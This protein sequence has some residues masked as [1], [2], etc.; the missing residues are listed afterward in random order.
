MDLSDYLKRGL[1]K[2]Q[3]PNF[4][5][6]SR[7]ILRAEKDLQSFDRL[8]NS[9][10]GNAMNL[11]Y[12]AMLKAGRALLYSFGYLP[13]DGQMH[14]TVVDIVAKILGEEYQIETKQFERY[15]KKRHVFIY[16]AEDCTESE[17]EKA[18]ETAAKLIKRVKEKIK[19]QNPQGEFDF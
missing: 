10:P 4:K 19:E 1:I 7:L 3:Q 8:I 6:I 13:A 11:A 2:K 5:Q 18:K 12:N 14:K 9:D 17:A 15:R 16:E